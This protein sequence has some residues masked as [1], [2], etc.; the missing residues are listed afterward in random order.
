MSEEQ[1]SGSTR[2]TVED[3]SKEE[4]IN[5]LI[6]A[7]EVALLAEGVTLEA[8]LLSGPPPS[9]DQILWNEAMPLMQR[10]Q[11]LQWALVENEQDFEV[12]DIDEVV[13]KEE[14]QTIK[15][16]SSASEPCPVCQ[17]EGWV[18][19]PACAGQW[20][21]LGNGL[22]GPEYCNWQG[23]EFERPGKRSCSACDGTGAANEQ[24][25]EAPQ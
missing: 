15:P 2:V 12:G 11:R 21:L 3:W 13:A 16:V 20:A 25:E 23:C 6:A 17:G 1:A 5:A 9:D 14:A 24:K 7:F 4:R 10:Q 8:L 19:C 18:P 22:K